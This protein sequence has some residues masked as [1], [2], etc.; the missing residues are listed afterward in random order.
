[1]VTLKE[2]KGCDYNHGEVDGNDIYAFVACGLST[3]AVRVKRT[4]EVV[5][6]PVDKV[7]KKTKYYTNQCY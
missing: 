6:C 7:T 1:M 4:T 3:M 2:C 5:V